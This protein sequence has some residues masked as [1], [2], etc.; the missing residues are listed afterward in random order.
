MKS[1]AETIL[2]A[3]EDLHNQEQIVTRETLSQLTGLKLSS[4]QQ[5]WLKRSRLLWRLKGMSMGIDSNIVTPKEEA[6]LKMAFRCI[7]QVCNDSTESS[8]ELGFN[9]TI[10]T[11]KQIGRAHV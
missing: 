7:R 2:E 4:K 9:A 3:I 5:L 8:R 6:L 10:V 11:G 1:N